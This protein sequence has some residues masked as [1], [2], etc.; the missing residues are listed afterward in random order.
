LLELDQASA[1][2]GTIGQMLGFA[3]AGDLRENLY[4]QVCL[5]RLGV[6][7]MTYSDHWDTMEEYESYV[8]GYRQRGDAQ[9]VNTYE[10]MRDNV[11]WLTKNSTEI[12]R[13]ADA[14]RLLLSIDSNTSMNMW[15]N[16]ADPLYVFVRD[17]QLKKCD[18]SDLAGEV[19][20]G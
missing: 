16:D 20:Q 9:L 3:S 11:I 13:G 4:R 17:E 10:R 14:W 7:E 8:A 1:P 18:F 15:I 5:A 12:Q 6:R 2:Q 19:T